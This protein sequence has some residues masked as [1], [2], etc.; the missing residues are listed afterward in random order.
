MHMFTAI[1]ATLCQ[2]LSLQCSVSHVIT[3][4]CC[5]GTEINCIAEEVCNKLQRLIVCYIN[6]LG[7]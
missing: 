5:V 7:C 2:V 3:E 1:F 4:V 6:E